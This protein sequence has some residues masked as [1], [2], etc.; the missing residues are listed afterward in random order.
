M[1]PNDMLSD[2]DLRA[3]LNGCEGVTPGPWKVYDGCSWR[4]I[5]T[6]PSLGRDYND[7]AVLYPNV[8]SD[9]HPDMNAGRGQD[10]YANLNHIARLDPTTVKSIVSELLSLRARRSSEAVADE[11]IGFADAEHGL[12][13]PDDQAARFKQAW[14]AL[15]PPPIGRKCLPVY[16][17]PQPL[18]AGTGETGK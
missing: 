2:D 8:A 6:A 1:T 14:D 3:I 5:G 18:G 11:P 7:C 4:R 15:P 12:L 9:G 16:L 13:I 10:T 17:S